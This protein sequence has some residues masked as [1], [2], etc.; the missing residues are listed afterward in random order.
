MHYANTDNA[1]LRRR[2]SLK[3]SFLWYSVTFTAHCAW[4]QG[5]KEEKKVLKV[6]WKKIA[7]NFYKVPSPTLL[8]QHLHCV[9]LWVMWTLKYNIFILI[10]SLNFFLR[11]C[12]PRADFRLPE[13]VPSTY[14]ARLEHS[15]RHPKSW[16]VSTCEVPCWDLPAPSE[17]ATKYR[18]FSGICAGEIPT[19]K[20][21]Q[22]L[23]FFHSFYNWIIYMQ[24]L[25]LKVTGRST[26]GKKIKRK[27][28]TMNI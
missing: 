12:K 6:Y 11:H 15:W 19:D 14:Q 28:P 2:A 1:N 21:Q 4:G 10:S 26:D 22:F 17:L 8:I 3:S 5:K 24:I 20:S 23:V 9:T 16:S 7:P 27:E 18:N 25:G 13:T